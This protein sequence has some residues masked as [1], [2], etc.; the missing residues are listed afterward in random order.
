MYTAN[1]KLLATL[2]GIGPSRARK[3][4]DLRKDLARDS[5]PYGN[6]MIAAA[7]LSASS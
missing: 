2:K 1:V 7:R 5:D 3:I 4:V 6:D